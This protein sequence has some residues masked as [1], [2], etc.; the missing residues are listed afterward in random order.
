LQ[1]LL[2]VYLHSIK[3]KYFALRHPG[4]GSAYEQISAKG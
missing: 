2:S 1:R 4:G 3:S